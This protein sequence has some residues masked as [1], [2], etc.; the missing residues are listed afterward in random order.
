MVKSEKH[1]AHADCVVGGFR[2]RQW[3]EKLIGTL[4]LGLLMMRLV[5]SCGFTSAFQDDDKRRFGQKKFAACANHPVLLVDAPGGP[6]RWSTERQRRM[7]AGR[8]RQFGAEVTYDHFHGRPFYR[9]GTKIVRWRKRQSAKARDTLDRWRN[10]EG[11]AI[12]LLFVN[13]YPQASGSAHSARWC[14]ASCGGTYSGVKMG[15]KCPERISDTA[16]RMRAGDT[17]KFEC[18]R[19]N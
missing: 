15:R 1:I 18:T 4:I 2:L 3:L 11:R 12:A 19:Q 17:P 16:R 10:K 7:G 6:S 8:F 13:R 14:S 5:T 9:H